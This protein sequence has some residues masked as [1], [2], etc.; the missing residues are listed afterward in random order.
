MGVIDIERRAVARDVPSGEE[1]PRVVVAD[2]ARRP[3]M[4][5]RI[6]AVANEKGGV[7][8]STVALHLAV[9]LAHAGYRVLAVDLD[10]RQQT[11]G[12]FCA[13]R[14]ATARRYGASLPQLRH[15]V[16]QQPS[17]AMLHQEIARVDADC[18]YVVI[19]APGHDCPIARRAVAMADCLVTPVSASFADI[20]LLGRFNP[21][22][23][24]YSG[25]GCFAEMVEGLRAERLAAGLPAQDWVVVRNRMRRDNSRARQQ[26]DA[27]LDMLA[28]RQGFRLEQGLGERAAYRE[29]AMLGLTHLDLAG[30]SEFGRGS[31]L[32][33]AEIAALR[34]AVEPA[35]A[36]A[37]P[38]RALA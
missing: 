4:A 34:L 12:R 9:A 8:K 31:S 16:P 28:Q 21:Y 14:E 25:P 38:Q 33:R 36:S 10:R 2:M 32:A 13:A 3:R 17:G 22:N 5:R 29:L 24:A 20:E 6:I 15:V 1:H 35:E 27:A 7:G 18:D 19:D 11:I 26:W 23:M 30:I 37:E